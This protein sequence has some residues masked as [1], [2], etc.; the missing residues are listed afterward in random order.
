MPGRPPVVVMMPVA[1]DSRA[2]LTP[3]AI[4]AMTLLTP[5]AIALPRLKTGLMMSPMARG[6]VYVKISEELLRDVCI[7]HL[8][9]R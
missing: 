5:L 3:L 1:M 9:F 2:L 7:N 6:S 4:G 8:C